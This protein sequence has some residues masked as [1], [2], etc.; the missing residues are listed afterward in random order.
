MWESQLIKEDS[1]LLQKVN[2]KQKKKL[3]KLVQTS[4]PSEY[5]GQDFTKLS[6]LVKELRSLDMMKSDKKM[7]KKMKKIDEANVSLIAAASE[8]RKDYETLYRQLRGMVYPK[9]KGDLGDEKDE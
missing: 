3:K 7:L 2:A 9:S 5:M 1:D 6:D 4:E 8:L